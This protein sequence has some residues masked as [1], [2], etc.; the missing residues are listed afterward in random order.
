MKWSTK[1]PD[2]II[3]LVKFRETAIPNVINVFLCN[4]HWV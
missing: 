1:N 3:D 2:G 4:S